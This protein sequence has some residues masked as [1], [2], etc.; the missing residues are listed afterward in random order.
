M[1]VRKEFGRLLRKALEREKVS[2][3]E[4]ADRLGKHREQISRYALG[5]GNPTLEMIHEIAE[6]LKVHP[7]RL[8]PYGDSVIR[9]GDIM[10]D[11]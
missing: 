6:A 10:E 11:R 4:L 1:N 8:F 5:E 9:L 2:Q 7:V 3:A